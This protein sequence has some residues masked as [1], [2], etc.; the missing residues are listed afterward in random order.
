MR[1]IFLALLCSASLVLPAQKT[2]AGAHWTF[3]AA[4]QAWAVV[5]PKG[6][7]CTDFVFQ[8]PVPF[9]QDLAAARKRNRYFLV[10]PEGK[11]L[12]DSFDL[13]LPAT[14]GY[15]FAWK[16]GQGMYWVNTQGKDTVRIHWNY[17]APGIGRQR[18]YESGKKYGLLDSTGLFLT[19]PMYDNLVRAG[20]ADSKTYI[21]KTGK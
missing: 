9:R 11:V 2:S 15:Y 21:A 1:W 5:N 14:E 16:K 18:V 4:R 10:L 6:V 17:P 8:D 13:L 7:T 20:E 3:N 19:P 12:P